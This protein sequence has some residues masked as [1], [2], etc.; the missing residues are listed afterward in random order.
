M[1]YLPYYYRDSKVTEEIIRVSEEETNELYNLLNHIKN[2]FSILS[3]DEKSITKYEKI[4]NIPTNTSL[5]LATRRAALIA[6][7]RSKKTATREHIEKLASD[8]MGINISAIENNENYKLLLEYAIGKGTGNDSLMIKTL[9]EI[10]P[11]HIKLEVQAAT[12]S[13]VYVGAYYHS[14]KRVTYR[15]QI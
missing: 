10:I 6:K 11:A 1:S 13:D 8:I 3:C 12:Y 2:Q 14:F 9:N 4:Y 7:I 15:G 5:P